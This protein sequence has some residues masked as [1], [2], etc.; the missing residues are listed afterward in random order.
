MAGALVQ[1]MAR[2]ALRS[3]Q[4]NAAAGCFTRMVGESRGEWGMVQ[5]KS[6]RTSPSRSAPSGVIL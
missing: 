3:R 6:L 5:G 2:R 4:A 1:T